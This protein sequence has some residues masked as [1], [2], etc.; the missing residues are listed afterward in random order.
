[1]LIWAFCAWDVPVFVGMIWVVD[2]VGALFTAVG[3]D[4]LGMFQE[5]WLGVVVVDAFGAL[6]TV[7]GADKLGVC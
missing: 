2:V 7:V 6:F 5:A 1:M 3:A 4:K